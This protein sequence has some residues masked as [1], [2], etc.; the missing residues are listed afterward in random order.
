MSRSPTSD[1]SRPLGFSIRAHLAHGWSIWSSRQPVDV[2]LAFSAAVARRVAETI[3]HPSQALASMESG[4]PSMRL[5]VADTTEIKQWVLD[6]LTVR[7][8]AA[9][10]VQRGDGGGSW[11][12]EA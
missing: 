3:R 12:D 6:G 2:H 9:G 8:A 1:F 7:G 10:R 4:R 11:D 5:R